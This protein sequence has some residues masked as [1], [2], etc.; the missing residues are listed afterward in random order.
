MLLADYLKETGKTRTTLAAELGISKP[1]LSKWT[2]IPDRWLPVLFPE[3]N[4]KASIDYSLDE[5]RALCKLRANQTDTN[6]AESVGL[7]LH[8]FQGMIERLRQ[9]GLERG[10]KQVEEMKAAGTWPPACP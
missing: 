3:D 5:I 10:Y 4:R 1:A 9:T 6:I 2:D 7:A 8:E